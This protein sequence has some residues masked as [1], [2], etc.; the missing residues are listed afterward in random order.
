M[1][2]QMFG[3]NLSN[4]SCFSYYSPNSKALEKG[5]LYEETIN[6]TAYIRKQLFW[7]KLLFCYN[8]ILKKMFTEQSKRFIST[9]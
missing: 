3:T 1:E 2:E 7:L 5:S 6:R 8:R 4:M 9:V